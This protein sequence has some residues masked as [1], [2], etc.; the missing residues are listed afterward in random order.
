MLLIDQ[1]QN[2]GIDLSKVL[3][4]EYNIFQTE[5][6]I[7]A[8]DILYN[9]GNEIDI[10]LFA[11]SRVT[12]NQL[13]VIQT[14]KRDET[15][16]KIPIIVILD[17]RNIKAEASVL[18]AGVDDVV[19]KPYSSLTAKRI[20]NAIITSEKRR[21]LTKAE[22]ERY[23]II[24]ELSGTLVLEWNFK[25]HTFY[26][27]EG[28]KDL[29]MGH[30]DCWAILENRGN[31]KAVHP[32]DILT[33]KKEFFGKIK[34]GK[35]AKALVRLKK[36][37]SSY[38]WCELS[39]T[40]VKDSDGKL[41]KV[42]GT[43]NLVDAEIT[44]RQKLKDRAEVDVLTGLHNKDSFYQKTREMLMENP[45]RKYIIVCIDIERFRMIND[46]FGMEEG[47]R[48]LKFVGQQ[49][50]LRIPREFGTVGRLSVDVFAMCLPDI[51]EQADIIVG[52]F[53]DQL[54]A[55]ELEFDINI[56]L[57]FYKI[58]DRKIPINF[59]C[60]RA[61]MALKTV[62]GNYLKHYAFYDETLR[63]E[64]LEEQNILNDMETA[65][66]KKQFEVYYQPVY[67]LSTGKIVS[68]EALVRWRHPEK[69]LLSPNS[70][71]PLFEHNGFVTKLDTY[72]WENVCKR[73]QLWKKLGRPIYPI[74]VNVSRV[75]LYDSNF[76]GELLALIQRYEIEPCLLK[77]EITESAYTENE[78]QLLYIMNQLQCSGFEI[79]MDDFGS[80]YSSLNMLKDVPVDVLKID[81]R[82]ISGVEVS[83]R[84]GSILA[85]VI[86]MARRLKLP[87]IAEGVETRE[88]A[89]Y[90]RLIGCDS[91]Q[92]YY[93]SRPIPIQ[94]FEKLLLD[95]KSFDWFVELLEDI[96]NNIDI[97]ALW[98]D[99][100]KTNNLFENIIGGIGLYEMTNG[101][102]I[103]FIKGNDSYY[104]LLKIPREYFAKEEESI[105]DKINVDE[106]NQIYE[107]SRIALETGKT[108]EIIF[109]MKNKHEKD[110][111][112]YLK[113]KCMGGDLNRS[114]FCVVVNDIT[115]LFY[116]YHKK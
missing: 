82:F 8:M 94:E 110:Y 84:A 20:D 73:I 116:M 106:R 113:V 88:Q 37:D 104:E 99:D 15:I 101:N 54:K 48:L 18:E 52:E 89:E 53:R 70:F 24:V 2:S 92:G 109:R 38:T 36:I 44:V 55:Y 19:I 90:L 56:A 51:D 3:M 96:Y 111:V 93:F 78:K 14:M 80:G 1:E 25:E 43:I 26:S 91:A 50:K 58:D 63:N 41:E 105:L 16:S 87:V 100:P 57:G 49:L 75:H 46:L 42:I 74:S 11:V 5:N 83:T 7:E 86:Q 21:C 62:K 102:S 65:L 115:N 69:G 59:M 45:G 81:M 23:H 98:M 47:D 27:S 32:D 34:A 68:A 112:I 28:F 61:I 6:R 4:D 72:V 33:L 71:L 108:Q 77:L 97:E 85:S 30:L 29:V 107:M 35:L 79:L 17:K 31:V 12:K 67:S 66:K 103:Q 114:V 95:N 22:E 60:D 9:K 13:K 10:I 40:C 64:M 76:C 39:A